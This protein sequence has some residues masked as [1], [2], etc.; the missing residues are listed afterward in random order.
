MTITNVGGGGAISQTTTTTLTG[1]KPTG[2]VA[3]DLLVWVYC[4]WTATQVTPPSGWQLVG[5]EA[6]RGT[7]VLYAYSRVADGSSADTPVQVFSA[8]GNHSGRMFAFRGSGLRVTG[9]TS[10]YNATNSAAHVTPGG[11]VVGNEGVIVRAAF[12]AAIVSNSTYTWPAN[13]GISGAATHTTSSGR[14]VLGSAVQTIGSP[15]AVP[16]VTATYSTTNYCISASIVVVSLGQAGVP[17]SGSATKHVKLGA[18]VKPVVLGPVVTNGGGA[19]LTNSVSTYVSPSNS[20]S[21]GVRIYAEGLDAGLPIGLLVHFHGDG[22]FEYDNPDSTWMMGGTNGIR[23]QA[24]KRN[25]ICVIANS[26]QDTG[27]RTWWEWYGTDEN[28]TYARDLILE[29]YSRFNIDRRRVYLSAYS[30][31]AQ[32]VSKYLVPKFAGQLFG[33]GGVILFSGGGEADSSVVPFTPAFPAMVPIHWCVGALD[34]GTEVGSDGFN[35]IASATAGLNW[36]QAR[37]CRVS[38]EKPSGYGHDLDGLF[39]PVVGQQLDL[40]TV[41]NVQNDRAPVFTNLAFSTNWAPA[42]NNRA[43]TPAKMLVISASMSEMVAGGGIQKSWPNLLADRFFI[44]AH[45]EWGRGVNPNGADFPHPYSWQVTATP[46]VN[47]EVGGH[48]PVRAGMTG[49]WMAY[50]VSDYV[51]AQPMLS[52]VSWSNYL[53]YSTG[54]ANTSTTAEQH[55]SWNPVN[56]ANEIFIG[57]KIDVASATEFS[58]GR[59]VVDVIPQGIW[60]DR[61][62]NP[63]IEVFNLSRSGTRADEWTSWLTTTYRHSSMMGLIESYNPHLVA[64]GS[65]GNDYWQNGQ[66]T[67]T[68]AT[69]NSRLDALY[70]RLRVLCPNA[71]FFSWT[72]PQVSTSWPSRPTWNTFCDWILAWC[73]GK[74]IPCLDWRVGTAVAGDDDAYYGS[75]E[76]HGNVLYSEQIAAL[77]AAIMMP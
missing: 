35:A 75:D 38:M 20:Y 47:P 26:P 8:S 62:A 41:D 42:L 52:K 11:A 31:G 5:T 14:R 59:D 7:S 24:K 23:A 53:D 15:D 29:L 68:Q 19:A 13:I 4:S 37:Q 76:V 70:A 27:N 10:R 39:G 57:P 55:T 16:S 21:S 51:S 46:Y 50:D 77:S 12:T 17:K 72:E 61:V 33:I 45:S 28:P 49:G 34:D 60:V 30:G 6:G 64:F 32:F 67:L 56:S 3:G 40:M 48:Y 63:Q 36:Y 71:D 69:L 9:F 54:G 1:V 65:W 44:P 18:I 66:G 74:G 43:V 25:L 2:V 58:I 73:A 22:G